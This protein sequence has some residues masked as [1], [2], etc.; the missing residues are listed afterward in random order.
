[1]FQ[2]YRSIFLKHLISPSLLFG[3]KER[4]QENK[5]GFNVSN[6]DLYCY[7]EREGWRAKNQECRIKA[8]EWFYP[9]NALRGGSSDF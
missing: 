8:E 5:K 9:P 7:V 1:M 2:R 6:P 4:Q 3:R